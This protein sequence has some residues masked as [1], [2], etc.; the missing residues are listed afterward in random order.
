MIRRILSLLAIATAILSL[1]GCYSRVETGE[2][3]LRRN[4]NGT[5]DTTVLQPGWHQTI[6]G[7]II[8]FATKEILLSEDKLTPQSADKSTLH[9]F[10]FNFTYT[11]DPNAVPE[12]YT[13]YSTTAHLMNPNK[14]E[15]FPMGQFVVGVVRASAYEAVSE[16]NV[17]ELNNKRKEIEQRIAKVANEKF[18][19]EKLGGKV[20]V[21]T[22][23]VKTIQPSQQVVDSANRAVQAQNDLLTKKT[24]VQIAAQEAERIKA[25][26][27][28]SGDTYIRLLEAQAKKQTAD[29]LMVA[30]QNKSAM[31][32]VPSQFTALGN[33]PGK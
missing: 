28:Q 23:N 14:S 5:I 31:W 10:D 29:A 27:A 1:T 25:L 20:T 26:S 2:V 13:K 3:A 6:V 8:I 11:I 24:E 12:F 4:F 17:L 7:D 16:F 15:I 32:V 21:T 18:T 22:V 30:A 9:E 33:V 19:N